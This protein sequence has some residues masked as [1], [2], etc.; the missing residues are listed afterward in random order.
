MTVCFTSLTVEGIVSSEYL[1]ACQDSYHKRL[2]NRQGNFPQASYKNPKLQKSSLCF[3]LCHQSAEANIKACSM[4]P[5]HT[6]TCEV[7]GVSG[8]EAP[9][10]P[11]TYRIA[12]KLSLR[13]PEYGSIILKAVQPSNTKQKG[14]ETGVGLSFF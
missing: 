14:A 9:S 11:I 3:H 1:Q 12:Q 2:E 7:E 4:M 5:S 13:T 6:T 10:I 8:H